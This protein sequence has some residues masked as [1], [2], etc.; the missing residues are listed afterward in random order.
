M[1]LILALTALTI[2]TNFEGASARVLDVSADSIRITP[3]G[4]SKRGMPNWWYLRVDGIDTNQP[5]TLEV[6]AREAAT[7]VEGSTDGKVVPLNHVWAFP[8]RA[9]ISID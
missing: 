3:A 6:V 7:P 5:F 4:D 8:T 9:A 1:S 2:S